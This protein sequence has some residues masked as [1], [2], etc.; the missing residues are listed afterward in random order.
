MKVKNRSKEGAIPK[1]IQLGLDFFIFFSISFLI[2]PNLVM[3]NF[4]NA[5]SL[6]SYPDRY[7]NLFNPFSMRFFHN[8]S[9]SIALNLPYSID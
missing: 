2:A 9:N 3:L 6:I 7:T 4:F 8:R 1:I 5:S